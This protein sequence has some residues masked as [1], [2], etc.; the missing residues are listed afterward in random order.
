MFSAV[1]SLH[2]FMQ[3]FQYILSQIQ[4]KFKELASQNSYMPLP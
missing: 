3:D 1:Y 2:T 4:I